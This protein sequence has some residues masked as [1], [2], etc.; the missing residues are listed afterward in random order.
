MRLKRFVQLIALTAVFCLAA[1]VAIADPISAA[2]I[3][4]VAGAAAA[5]PFAVGALTIALQLAA[6]IGLSY[7]SSLLNKP[8]KEDVI[9]G[10][11]G[12]LT[13]GGA[14][15]RSFIVG[16]GMTAGSLVYAGTWGNDG[17]SPNAVLVM[18]IALSDLPCNRLMEVWVNGE[19]VTWNSAG[20]DGT[21][22]TI[23]EYTVGADSFLF[24][25]YYRGTQVVA[26][27][28][29]TSHFGTDPDLPWT[30][31]MVG[32]GVAYAVIAARVN[33]EL[34]TGFPEFK[35]VLE[36]ISLYDRR[37]DTTA[38]GSG[39]QLLADPTTWTFNANNIVIEENI[40]RGI[41]YGGKWVYGAQTVASAQLPFTAWTAAANECD[42]AIAL[43]AGGTEP[44][45][46]AGGEIKFDDEPA[47]CLAELMKGCNGK[48]AEIGGV[49]K[50][51]AGAPGTSVF[52]FSDSDIL[53][54]ETQMF[55]PFP[56]LGDTINHLT[57]RYTSPAEGWNIKDAPPLITA[58]YET[59]DDGRRQTSSAT[60]GFVTSGTM[61][62]RLMKAELATHRAWRRHTL[63]MPPDGFVIEPLDVVTWSSTRNGYSSKTFEI[64][65]IED[66]PNFCV[67]L[68][69]REL[70]PTAYDWDET[71]NEQTVVNNPIV[72]VRPAPQGI[73][74]WAANGVT[75]SANGMVRP[76]IELLWEPEEDDVDGIQFEVRLAVDDTMVYAGDRDN[77]VQLSGSLI[78]S[79]GLLPL[80][81]YEVRGRLRPISPRPADWSSWISVTTPDA[82]ISSADLNDELDARIDAIAASLGTLPNYVEEL[83][84]NL[85]N[86]ANSV[87][88]LNL[89][90]IDR[91]GNVLLA[92]GARYNENKAGVA[93][94]L[95]AVADV[96][97][98]L[99]AFRLS[100]FAESGGVSAEGFIRFAVAT[101]PAGAI[102]S[103][104]IEVNTGTV[105]TP[106]WTRA[107][108]YLD[109]FAS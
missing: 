81:Q 59:A 56:S 19:K 34:F 21:F 100:L 49:Y 20:A 39:S 98:A 65:S 9:G 17:K 107:G 50:P 12:R 1:D 5:T 38:G 22:Q 104:A 106:N 43:E 62:Q 86:L 16:K 60:Y 3:T 68:V 64:I 87:G 40:L 37:L 77:H 8:G 48:L 102:A 41:K 97:S 14:V 13:A 80:T 44:Q 71:V 27:S 91:L 55:E 54:S 15:P 7:L 45:F 18:V 57:A 85:D 2:I 33:D 103:F 67:G 99:A 79:Q 61:V 58:A 6:G 28:Y 82:R 4:I 42:V 78:I 66:L 83:R 76:A 70:D 52:S 75:I 90:Q 88:Q 36:G 53:S 63:P 109:A 11:T 94:A 31:A 74:D 69:V 101:T 51:R 29:L 93:L 72:I 92:V 23:P 10:T 25:K 95:D 47:A 105:D 84:I 35:F 24:V 108:I 26:D 32:E 73:V 96:D 89:S 46:Y 30:S